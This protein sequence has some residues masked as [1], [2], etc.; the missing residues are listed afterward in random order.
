MQA[1]KGEDG[2]FIHRPAAAP[3]VTR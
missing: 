2:A 3:P 1:S